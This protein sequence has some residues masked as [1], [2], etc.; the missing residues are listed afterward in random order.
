MAVGRGSAYAGG[1]YVDKVEQQYLIRGIGLMKSSDDIG[2]IVVTQHGGTPLLIRDISAIETGG[3][4]RQ[5]LTGED[6]EDDVI[7]GLVLMRKREN[8]SV[9]RADLEAGIET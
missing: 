9:V 8:P 6:T 7:T 3:V 4:P 5:G 2:N 1:V